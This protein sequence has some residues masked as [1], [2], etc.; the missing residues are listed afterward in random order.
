MIKTYRKY[1]EIYQS[2][3]VNTL[4]NTNLQSEYVTSDND[5]NIHED[6]DKYDKML[7]E[8]D[9][10]PNINIQKEHP[11]EVMACLLSYYISNDKLHTDY[12]IHKWCKSYL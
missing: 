11:F 2:D 5:K 12:E 6:N 9:K 3:N 10:Y 1:Y 8:L 7:K 4:K